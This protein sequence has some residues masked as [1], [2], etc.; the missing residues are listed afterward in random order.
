MRSEVWSHGEKDD[1]ARDRFDHPVAHSGLQRELDLLPDVEVLTTQ[2]LPES[3]WA[4]EFDVRGQ[5]IHVH[6]T[7]EGLY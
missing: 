4:E 5:P 3:L 2:A 7:A 1:K 6:P